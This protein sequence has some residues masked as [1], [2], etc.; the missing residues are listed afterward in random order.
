M[1][2][3]KLIVIDSAQREDLDD[4]LELLTLRRLPLDGIEDHLDSALVARRDGV[5]VGCAAVEI[6]PRAGLLRS[7]AV[8]PSQEKQGL[9]GQLVRSCLDLGR[10]HG[11]RRIFLLTESAVEYFTRFGFIKVDRALVDLPVRES[12]EF[13]TACPDDA[14]AMVLELAGP[15]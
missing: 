7:V 13:T 9:G 12:V 1:P 11:L 3:I 15:N 2:P 4:V 10:L 8:H 14:Q 5:L 6:Y